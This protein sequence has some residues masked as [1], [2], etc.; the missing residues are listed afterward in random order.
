MEEFLKKRADLLKKHS[1]P[2]A[3]LEFIREYAG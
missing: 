3:G 1:G 2:D